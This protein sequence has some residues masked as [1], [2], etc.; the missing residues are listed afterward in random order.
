MSCDGSPDASRTVAHWPG[1]F[2]FPLIRGSA[3]VAVRSHQGRIMRNGR[4]APLWQMEP[5]GTLL[6]SMTSPCR[7]GQQSGEG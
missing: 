4:S 6:L 2:S 1:T 3:G 7:A 5:K